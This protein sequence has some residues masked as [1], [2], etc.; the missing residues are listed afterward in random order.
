[1]LH[2]DDVDEKITELE[3][4]TNILWQ[5]QS[6]GTSVR[7]IEATAPSKNSKKLAKSLTRVQ[8]YANRLCQAIVRGWPPGCH[9]THE[10]RLMLKDRI[11]APAPSLKRQLDFNLI[12]ASDFMATDTLWY[13]GNVEVVEGNDDFSSTFVQSPT[14]T[15]SSLT[16]RISKPTVKF[17]PTPY[18]N[19]LLACAIEVNNIC[20]TV[21]QARQQKKALKWYLMTQQRLHCSHPPQV[22]HHSP[23]LQHAH[24]VS[25]ASL[26]TASTSTTDRSKKLPL[27]PRLFLA[28]NLASTL[29]QLNTTPWLGNT[30][31]KDSIYFLSQASSGHIHAGQGPHFVNP[32]EVDLRQ[33]LVTRDFGSTP[34]TWNQPEP[35]S[36][37]LELGIMLLEL[38]HETTIEEH[39]SGSGLRV[40]D[41]YYNRLSLAQRWL[42]DSEDHL[43][44]TYFNVTARCVKCSFDGIPARPVWDDVLFKGIIQGVVEPLQEECRPRNRWYS[45][46]QIYMK[47]GNVVR[48][49]KML[50]WE[51]NGRFQEFYRVSKPQSLFFILH[52]LSIQS[53]FIQSNL[54]IKRRSKNLP[55]IPMEKWSKRPCPKF[56]QSAS[57]KSMPSQASTSLPPVYLINRTIHLHQK[58]LS[59]YTTQSTR[60]KESP[61]PT[62][63]RP[64]NTLPTNMQHHKSPT[65]NISPPTSTLLPPFSNPKN[66]HRRQKNPPSRLTNTIARTSTSLHLNR[67]AARKT[68]HLN[69]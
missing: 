30:W 4:C 26:L 23:S 14:I 58:P 20:T 62:P 16:N 50:I 52:P 25:L 54:H 17:S 67:H 9:S 33:P 15:N 8:G 57:P 64:T 29:I 24:T 22:S 45:T 37:I 13:E 21:V 35:R 36:M 41:Q 34:D 5:L 18:D 63:F 68:D 32:S 46:V 55:Q 56:F 3:R 43:T 44:P 60:P 69:Q 10:A 49:M 42:D 59:N 65:A 1:M 7:Q 2:E 66:A 53:I 6:I 48:V 38:G 61:L 28:L 51:K 47:D 12:F 19:S 40:D 27:K 39:F 31:S 11:E